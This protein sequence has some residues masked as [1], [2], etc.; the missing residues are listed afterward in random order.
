MD[1]DAESEEDILA[2]ANAGDPEAQN[3]MGRLV[4]ARDGMDAYA[5]A[6]EWFR[7]AAEQGLTKA[8]HN[9]GVL[10]LQA[11]RVRPDATQWFW[12]AGRE[13][14][15][16]SI[17]AMGVI[18]R[19]EGRTGDAEKFFEIAAQRGH[20]ESQDA[21]GCIYFERDTDADHVI[22]RRWSEAA[23]E[24]GVPDALTRM[25]TIYH[26]GLGIARDPQRAAGYFYAA[27]CKGHPGAQMMFGVACDVG[28]GVPIDRIE[29]AQ[30][31]M[32]SAEQ[33]LE[34]AR[35]YLP[36]VVKNLQEHEIDEAER[37]SREPLPGPTLS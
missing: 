11:G 28:A 17:F 35:M 2:Q 21:L 23:A 18:L 36:S 9:L 5:E 8:K 32:R 16:P 6:E 14:W 13:G 4:I 24:Q 3:A 29:A 1:D 26:E 22:A 19:D 12:E 10:C 25:G 7:R 20:A 15:L 31:L 30:W 37:R 27:A 34:L 33:G